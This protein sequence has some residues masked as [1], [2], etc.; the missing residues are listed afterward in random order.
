MSATTTTRTIEATNRSTKGKNEAR[1]SRADGR[2]PANLLDRG[3]SKSIEVNDRDF[4]KLIASG[5]RPSS[6]ITL[7]LDNQDI[8]VIAK[9]IHRHP[10][11]RKI[12][13]IDFYKINPGHKFRVKIAVELTGQAKGVKAGGALEHYIRQLKIMTIPEKVVEKIEVD[14]SDLGVGEAVH[15]SQLSIPKEWDL[16]LTGNPVVCR[17]AQSRMTAKAASESKES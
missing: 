4:E 3:T 10:V 5:L 17:V 6:K 2:I 11:S 9:E 1:R 15:L 14:I 12:Y 16:R 13:H 7:K 8:E